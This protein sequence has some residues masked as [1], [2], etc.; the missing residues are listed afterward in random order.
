VESCPEPE[1][2]VSAVVLPKP[3]S[4]LDPKAA[5]GPK[6]QKESGLPN[7]P[8]LPLPQGWLEDDLR[9][10]VS[11]ILVEDA[12]PDEMKG[13]VESDFKR[14]VY[15]LGLVPE[16]TGMSVLELG[17]NPYFMTVMLSKFRDAKLELANF[18]GGSEAE[19]SQKVFINQTDEV[20]SFPYKQFNVEQDVFPYADNSFDVVLFCEIIEHL[21]SDP[22][23]ALLEIRRV[24]KPGG[25]LVLTTPNVSRLDNVRKVIAGENIYDP[26]SGYG[27]YGRH[28]REYTPR[29]LVSLLSANGFNVGTLFTADVNADQANSSVSIEAVAPLVRHRQP[30]LGQYIFCR[31]SVQKASK[32]QPAVRA[33]WLYRSIHQKPNGDS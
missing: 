19:G 7:A 30:D 2:I 17:A 3:V 25:I 10:L 1:E 4:T 11:S 6:A 15:T 21:L 27:P 9:A 29:D 26:Y 12:P 18:F 8:P 23:H 24:L 33:E 22:V 14:F 28:N 20:V 31:S 16:R 13:Y 5:P 32:Q